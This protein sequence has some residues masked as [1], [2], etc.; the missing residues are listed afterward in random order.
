VAER[1][2]LRERAK[3]PLPIGLALV[4]AVSI[5]VGFTLG[6]DALQ[7]IGLF[8]AISAPIL[9]A[10]AMGWTKPILRPPDPA[11]ER[12][13]RLVEALT[14]ATQVISA[15]EREVS[16]RSVLAERLQKDVARHQELLALDRQEVEA[17]AQT[18]R[19]EVRRESRRSF[20]ASLLLNAFFFG[21]GILVTVLLT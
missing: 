21:L 6:V 9:A 17:V 19:L 18:F 20:F 10:D 13:K 16:A 7:L 15:I 5:P 3:W 8:S 14:E 12:V 4:A 11:E 1:R 2:S